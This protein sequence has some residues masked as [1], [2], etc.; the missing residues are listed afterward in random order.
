MRNI[1]STAAALAFIVCAGVSPAQAQSA[2]PVV[3]FGVAG[4][5][6]VPTGNFNDVHNT[7]WNA[8]ALLGFQAPVSPIGF[9]IDANYSHLNG[10]NS[11]V[12]SHSRIWSGTVDAIL[13][14]PGLVVSPYAIGGIGV[15]NLKT[16]AG[17]STVGVSLPS[18]EGSVTKFGWN[19][20]GGLQF[21]TPGATIFT[22]ARFTSIMT[23]GGHTNLVP[24]EVGIM[25]P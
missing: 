20:G 24:I 5:A 7:G 12:I 8:M 9:R 11:A 3:H 25:F 23:D 13:H 6:T 19:V 1:L 15:Y 22:E 17:G 18:D 10:Q 14:A 16:F 4:G 21:H 2:Y